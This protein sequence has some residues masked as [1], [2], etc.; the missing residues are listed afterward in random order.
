MSFNL[1]ALFHEPDDLH[2][3]PLMCGTSRQNGPEYESAEGLWAASVN[4]DDA[5]A[6]GDEERRLREVVANLSIQCSTWKAQA[7][8]QAKTITDLDRRTSKTT[9]PGLSNET[10]RRI[11]RL[12]SEAARLRS[13][14]AQLKETFQTIEYENIKL[15][16]QNDSKGKKLKGANKMAKNAK[17]VAGK[18][19]E[20][21]KGAI[22]DKQ[23]HLA[24]ERKMKK[25]RDEAQAAFQE[26]K[27]LNGDLLAKLEV[28][29]SGAPL[30]RDTAT[31]PNHIVAVVPIQFEIRRTDVQPIMVDLIWHQTNMTQNFE[32]WYKEKVT[33][34]AGIRRVVGANYVEDGKKK[35][36][37]YEDMIEMPNG[38]ME[39]GAEHD[40]WR[41]KLSAEVICRHAEAHHNSET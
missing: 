6:K 31:D 34:K 1:D 27:K 12:E 29:Q 26:Q 17:E 37:I 30:M 10:A 8:N 25:E 16:N 41:S 39:T 32:E 19:G 35:A 24:S 33:A 28:E 11:N 3:A 23:R 40:G 9:T 18:E 2:P 15:E 22:G 13:E 14:N 4:D 36:R 7:E 38:Y 20:K 5:E 21:A